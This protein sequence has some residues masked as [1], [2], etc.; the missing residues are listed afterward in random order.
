MSPEIVQID[1]PTPATGDTVSSVSCTGGG[2]CGSSEN[3]C[4][5]GYE[6]PDSTSDNS[7]SSDSE[8]YK[9]PDNTQLPD[10]SSKIPKICAMPTKNNGVN[11]NDKFTPMTQEEK[12][13]QI[14]DSWKIQIDVFPKKPTSRTLS[15]FL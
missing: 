5:G 11:N 7:I 8:G 14:T 6:C 3:R 12:N 15:N 13:K 9:W 1:Q 2:S 10:D 4:S